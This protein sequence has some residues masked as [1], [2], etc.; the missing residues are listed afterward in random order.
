MIKLVACAA[1]PLAVFAALAFVPDATA[2]QGGPPVPFTEAFLED[3]ENIS[4]GEAFWAAQC[5]HCHGAKA[6]P[7]KAPKLTPRRYKPEFVYHRTTYGFRKMPAWEN[8]YSDEER[9]QITAYVLS[10][11]FSP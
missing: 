6:Y 8:V 11:R 5:R 7:G 4:A 3:P 10:G 9:M 1:A 2:Q